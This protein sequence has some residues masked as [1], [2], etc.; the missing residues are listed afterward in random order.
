MGEPSVKQHAKEDAKESN[1]LSKAKQE[2]GGVLDEYKNRVADAYQRTTNAKKTLL[3]ASGTISKNEF[4]R[5]NNLIG[6]FNRDAAGY[7][8]QAAEAGMNAMPTI[9]AV[10]AGE[11]RGRL[12][13]DEKAG[14]GKYAVW[15]YKLQDGQWVKQ[16][17][18]TYDT[19]DAESASNYVAQVKAVDG[20]TA[21]SN[22]PNTTPDR[23]SLAGRSAKGKL[24][25]DAAD[26]GT[27]FFVEF[28]PSGSA[29][30]STSEEGNVFRG[31]WSQHGASVTMAAG[32]ST[33]SGQIQGVRITGTRSRRKGNYN[34]TDD[35]W[36]LDLSR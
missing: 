32:A 26:G 31:S 1:D 35:S 14:K 8:R 6:E 36:F 9:A 17:D 11:L 19:D 20:W 21:T 18:R 16:P 3:D 24:G 23:P 33:F 2:V 30:M 28:E 25:S 27:D 12:A 13:D 7:N 22:L 34:P 10:K 15:V 29:K 5:V 4:Q